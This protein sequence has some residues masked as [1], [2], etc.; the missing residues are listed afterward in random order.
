MNETAKKVRKNL[1]IVQK[2][3]NNKEGQGWKLNKIRVED[4][5]NEHVPG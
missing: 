4:H 1:N 5:I 3:N 2:S